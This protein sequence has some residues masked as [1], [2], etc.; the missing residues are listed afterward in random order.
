MSDTGDQGQDGGAA[1]PPPGA[2]VPPPAPP[3]WQPPPPGTMPPPPATTP[4]P[5][6]GAPPPPPAYPPAPAYPAVPTG[7]PPQ[8]GYGYGTPYPQAP[9]NDGMSIAGLCCGI[10]GIP[11]SLFCGLGL[12]LGT[13]GLVFGLIGR[14][15]IDRSGGLL[16]GRGMALA[17]AICGGVGIALSVGY[18]ILII[19]VNV[20]NSSN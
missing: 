1:A 19:A 5:A 2:P 3:G 14:S 17:G 10:A 6:Y 12:V 20:G 15:R 8:P 7:Y 11:L 4:P 18:W 9:K 16:T 13:L